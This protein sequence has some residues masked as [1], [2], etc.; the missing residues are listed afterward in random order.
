MA[1]AC[2]DMGGP[3]P[4]RLPPVAPCLSPDASAIVGQMQK[5]MDLFVQQNQSLQSQLLAAATTNRSAEEMQVDADA[6]PNVSA[7]TPQGVTEA[8]LFDFPATII[9]KLDPVLRAVCWKWYNDVRTTVSS[10]TSQK[11]LQEKYNHITSTNEIMRQFAMESKRAWQ[12]PKLYKVTAK[13]LPLEGVVQG[14]YDLDSQWSRMRQRHASECQN[15][16]IGH[17]ANAIDFAARA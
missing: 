12:F 2:T 16:F 3:L 10:Y 9:A 5:M 15:F 8:E 4:P 13:A 7:T 17:N 14:S 1:S 11:R 6:T